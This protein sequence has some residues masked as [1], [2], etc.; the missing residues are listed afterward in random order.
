MGGSEADT[1]R[2]LAVRV[3]DWQKV[4]HHKQ[5]FGCIL[6]SWDIWS[7]FV[8]WESTCV[9]R[10]VELRVIQAQEH[11]NTVPHTVSAMPHVTAALL[12]IVCNN[13][14]YGSLIDT[15]E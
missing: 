8:L 4:G 9:V 3:V 12:K 2:D 6:S 10:F 11:G 14:M 5:R 15:Q 7:K 13:R 1:H